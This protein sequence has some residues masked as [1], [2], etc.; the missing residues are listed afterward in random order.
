MHLGH[1]FRGSRTFLIEQIEVVENVLL[2][3]AEVSTPLHPIDG[4]AERPTPVTILVPSKGLSEFAP[5]DRSQKLEHLAYPLM[6]RWD[7]LDA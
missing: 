7:S 6:D 3:D 1:P 5:E 4:R 2:D